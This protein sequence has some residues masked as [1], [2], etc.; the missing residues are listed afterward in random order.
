MNWE[1]VMK[2]KLSSDRKFLKPSF[3]MILALAASVRNGSPSILGFEKAFAEETISRPSFVKNPISMRPS[4]E[5]LMSKPK[6]QNVAAAEP[7]ASNIEAATLLAS[8][9]ETA[10]TGGNI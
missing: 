5:T 9:G 2:L 3:V 8:K 4:A 10:F 7:I 1:V 6:P